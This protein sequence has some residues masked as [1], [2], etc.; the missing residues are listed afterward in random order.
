[1]VRTF[2]HYTPRTPRLTFSHH[3]STGPLPLFARLTTTIIPSY[4]L[5]TR[6]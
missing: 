6:P 5:D 2:D 4:R 1:M 3:R